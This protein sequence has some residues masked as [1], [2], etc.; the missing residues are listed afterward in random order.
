MCRYRGNIHFPFQVAGL[1]RALQISHK[2]SRYVYH[3]SF[4][5]LQFLLSVSMSSWASQAHAFHQHVLQRLSWLHHW[6]IPYV[7]IRG[8]ISPS[9]W[10]PD[11]QCKPAQVAHWI[12][13][14][15]F[16]VAWHCRSVWLLPCQFAA[17]IGGLALSMAKS[18]WHGAL[19]STYNTCTHGHLYWKRGGGEKRT[20]N[21]SLNFFQVVF[22]P[23]VVQSSQPSAAVSR[24]PR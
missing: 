21:N 12:W 1:L 13:W 10:G 15:L 2:I 18:Y 22:T 23:V 20:G 16:L 17:D 3:E 11:T 14:R 5:S 6:S 19:R 7:H 9:E 24:S 8:A 4:H